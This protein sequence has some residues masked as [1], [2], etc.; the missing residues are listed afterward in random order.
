MKKM[1]VVVMLALLMIAHHVP[2]MAQ[3]DTIRV[4]FSIYDNNPV[5]PLGNEGAWDS[6]SVTAARVVYKDDRFHM[7]YAGSEGYPDLAAV[8]YATSEDGRTWTRYEGNPVLELDASLAQEEGASLALALDGDTWVLYV[9]PFATHNVYRATAPDPTG[10]WTMDG[11]PVLE[12]DNPG[13]WDHYFQIDSIVQLDGEYVLYYTGHATAGI[14]RATSPDGVFWLKHKHPE[15]PDGGS[16]PVFQPQFVGA[17]WDR[18]SAS[19]AIVRH[20]DHGWELFY[21]GGLTDRTVVGTTVGYAT[22]ADGITWA[23]YGEEPI[24]PLEEGWRHGAVSVVVVEDTYYL[25]Y[26]MAEITGTGFSPQHG[27]GLATGSI[28]RE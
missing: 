21:T 26:E 14:G 12:S 2:G 10:P 24:L 7:L 3:G 17:A 25:Y 13:T 20:S 19:N 1:M 23:R 6:G 15:S 11:A 28:T 27:I 4:E 5:L 9:Q 16:D 22:S 18:D 8:G